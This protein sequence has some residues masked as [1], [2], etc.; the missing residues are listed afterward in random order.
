MPVGIELKSEQ[1]LEDMVDILASLHKY[2]PT[3]TT[4][5]TVTLPEET[6]EII[7]DDFFQILL[8]GYTCTCMRALYVC[9]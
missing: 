6:S 1:K 2:I 9:T 8:G 3:V 4:T 5:K 7:W